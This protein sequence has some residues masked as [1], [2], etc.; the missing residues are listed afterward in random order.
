[1]TWWYQVHILNAMVRIRYNL[2]NGLKRFPDT[3]CVVALTS[4]ESFLFARV[5]KMKKI[6]LTQGKYAIVD[7]EDYESAIRFKWHIIQ[8]PKKTNHYA[9]NTMAMGYINNKR[10]YCH[11]YLHR[12]IMRPPIGMEVDHINHDGLDCRRTNMRICS[13]IQNLHNSRIYKNNHSG[14][15]GV[16]L[17]KSRN[18]WRARIQ[19]RGKLISLG[20]YSDKLDAAKAYNQKAKELYG[21]F[22][23]LNSI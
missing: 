5:T 17:S 3:S 13:K 9:R 7:D 23:Y 4:R 20:Y 15:K 2:L 21:V 16:S 14:Y 12:L 22:A 10:R 8:S 6:P 11:I 19:H 1:M 18:K